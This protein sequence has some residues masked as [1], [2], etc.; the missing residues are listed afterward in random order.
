MAIRSADQISIVDLTDGYSVTLTSDGYTFPGTTSAA[1]AGSC[2]TQ[3]IAL[4][5]SEQVAATVDLNSIRFSCRCDICP[6]FL[7]A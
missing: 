6:C 4:R 3:I 1:K 7:C 5:G 2:T